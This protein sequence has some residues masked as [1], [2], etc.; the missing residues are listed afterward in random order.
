MVQKVIARRNRIEYPAH[1]LRS[2]SL[3]LLTLR[4]SPRIDQKF[5]ILSF[6]KDLL[7]AGTGN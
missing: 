6:A 7:L 4:P 2:L 1:M 5:V 3:C